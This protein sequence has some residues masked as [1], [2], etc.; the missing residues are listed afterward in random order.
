M[1]VVYRARDPDLDRVVAI[2]MLSPAFLGS[3][4][5]KKRFHRE[6]RAAASRGT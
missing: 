2:K 1:G 3:E 4:Q 5:A 6:A